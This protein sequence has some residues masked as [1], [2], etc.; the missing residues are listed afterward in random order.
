MG[1]YERRRAGHVDVEFPL[2]VR[3]SC[4]ESR[5]PETL[6]ADHPTQALVQNGHL[7][8]AGAIAS[9]SQRGR[10]L[11]RVPSSQWVTTQEAAA[12]ITQLLTGLDLCPDQ[13][14]LFQHV[15]CRVGVGERERPLPLAASNGRLALDETWVQF[16][17]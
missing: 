14:E 4:S 17:V 3:Q 2:G 8:L 6:G 12:T 1:R 9:P 15:A 7:V 11:Q 13:R 16:P 5:D 10:E